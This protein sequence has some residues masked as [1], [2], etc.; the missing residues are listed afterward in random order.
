[1]YKRQ[2][3]KCLKETES[4]DRELKTIKGI[5]RHN[6]YN[7]NIVDKV[8]KRVNIQKAKIEPEQKNYAGSL[9]YIGSQ[10]VYKRQEQCSQK[11]KRTKRE[12]VDK[13]GNKVTLRL[14]Q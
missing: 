13:T 14:N 6:N 8:M 12:V 10:D 2:D 9:T 11:S 4:K 3:Q 7:T 5:V 1:M